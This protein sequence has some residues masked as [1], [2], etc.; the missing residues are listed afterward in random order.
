[1]TREWAILTDFLTLIILDVR[2]K[3]IFGFLSFFRPSEEEIV[4]LSEKGQQFPFQIIAFFN[5]VDQLS[6]II[7]LTTEKLKAHTVVWMANRIYRQ[8]FFFCTRI[9]L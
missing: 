4:Y 8:M 2:V 7:Y 5:W 3:K 1:M 6:H 9:W